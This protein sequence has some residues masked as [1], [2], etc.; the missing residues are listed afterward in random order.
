[1]NYRL[2]KEDYLKMREH[3]AQ[4]FNR[5]QT[6]MD[7]MVSNVAYLA[8]GAAQ[9]AVRTGNLNVCMQAVALGT[10]T[11]KSTSA[12]AYLAQAYL[13]DPDFS[14][15]FVVSTIEMGIEAQNSIESLSGED[16]TTLYSSLHKDK[17]VDRGRAYEKLGYVPKRLVNKSELKSSRIVIVTHA[18]LLRELKY[19]IDEG[20]LSYL[21]KSRDVVFIDE[22][23]DLVDVVACTP[24]DIQGLY[25]VLVK[26][27]HAHPWLPVLSD[28]SYRMNKLQQDDGPQYQ[29][30]HLMSLE[31]AE[32]FVPEASAL[33][34]ELTNPE[35][36]DGLRHIEMERYS[37][38]VEFC[39]AAGKGCTF[40]SRGETTFFSYRLHFPS[41]YPGFVLLDAT[42]DLTGLTLLHPKVQAVEVPQVRYDNL[43]TYTMNLPARLRKK[44]D[45]IAK[46]T[47]GQEYAQY[48]RDYVLSN[49]KPGAEVLVVVWKDILTQELIGTSDDPKQPLDWEGRRV[50]T[51][52]WG[53]GIGLNKYKH[54][55][56]VFLF[57]EYFPLTSANIGV[58]QAWLQ[59][60]L[61]DNVLRLAVSRRANGDTYLPRGVYGETC[62]G[63]VLRWVKQLAMRGTA[64]EID[65][66]GVCK[67]MKLFTTMDLALL[68]SNMGRLFPGAP[69][70]KPANK[71]NLSRSETRNKR[72]A[73]VH[74]LHNTRDRWC[75]G[76]DEVEVATGI[77]QR[78]ISTEF[79]E[80]S[81]AVT[82]IGWEIIAANKLGKPGRMRYVVNEARRGR[83][84]AGS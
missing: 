65:E 54:K 13:K 82:S 35:L 23:P 45:V 56:H 69:M 8:A 75:F 53:A 17:G 61:S 7:L 36:S 31:E 21:G 30:A 40:Y 37:N 5:K 57:G 79:H 73:F 81:E 28:L 43:D 67:P 64:R 32:V 66:Y 14:G 58:T 15:A 12:Y 72:E 39:R 25:D 83:L 4:L 55:T 49:T 48:L 20:T 24:K 46:K 84:S 38:V 27:N 70:P 71:S 68:M 18:Q 76:A 78:R 51:Q 47:L 1:M 52:N 10:G 6:P 50:N 9:E 41:T 29:Y 16:T 26:E 42:S 74:L 2:T 80:I 34:W 19:G 33:L 59:Q 22:H 77:E 11:G 44:R 63:H 62:V 60:P 3:Q